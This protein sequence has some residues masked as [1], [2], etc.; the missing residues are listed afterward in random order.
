M[1]SIANGHVGTNVFT[2][3]VYMNGVYNGFKGESHRARIPSR[4][5]IRILTATGARDDE[6]LSLDVETGKP[7]IINALCY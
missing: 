7:F 1:P 2:D 4:N 5:N 6:T 3:T